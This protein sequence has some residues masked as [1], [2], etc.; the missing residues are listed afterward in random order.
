MPK[1]SS[2]FLIMVRPNGIRPNGPFDRIAF[3][4]MAGH[5]SD[6]DNVLFCPY[7]DKN[8]VHLHIYSFLAALRRHFY[9]KKQ[10]KP[11]QKLRLI[12]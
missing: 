6:Q 9:R 5:R 2:D 4:H 3:G 10:S 7:D 1:A 12:S 8:M 11:A